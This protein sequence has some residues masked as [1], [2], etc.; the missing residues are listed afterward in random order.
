[1]RVIVVQDLDPGCASSRTVVNYVW[2]VLKVRALYRELG[3]ALLEVERWT[4]ALNSR[5]Q[6]DSLLAEAQALLTELEPQA[7][8]YDD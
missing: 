4:N 7:N 6:A 3:H 5:R 2:A 1:V 8:G